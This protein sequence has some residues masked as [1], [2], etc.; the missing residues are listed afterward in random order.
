MKSNSHGQQ[1]SQ[2]Q[3]KRLC[4]FGYPALCRIAET[5]RDSDIRPPAAQGWERQSERNTARQREVNRTRT[6]SA[7]SKDL[8]RSWKKAEYWLEL[9]A[10]SGFFPE[11][12]LACAKKRN[13]RVEGD[14][15]Q[16]RNKHQSQVQTSETLDLRFRRS[17][18]LSFILL[19]SSLSYILHPLYLHPFVAM[20]VSSK[21]SP[22][23]HRVLIVRVEHEHDHEPRTRLFTL[24]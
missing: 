9:L 10:E 8:S 24:L 22:V 21:C 14:I 3:N 13:R 2:D 19:P 23:S 5:H 18:N 20:I 15:R 11:E 6:S 1:R 17:L 16:H 4:S 7:R 12:R